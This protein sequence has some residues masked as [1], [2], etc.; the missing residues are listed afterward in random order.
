MQSVGG[1][2]HSK[3]KCCMGTAAFLEPAVFLLNQTSLIWLAVDR[4]AVREGTFPLPVFH[5]HLKKKCQGLTLD[6]YFFSTVFFLYFFLSTVWNQHLEAFNMVGHKLRRPKKLFRNSLHVHDNHFETVHFSVLWQLL[7]RIY[8][9][10]QFAIITLH[11][12]PVYAKFGSEI[13]T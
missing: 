2:G 5:R 13:F 10:I 4:L 3:A 6:K 11:R 1:R 12:K 8:W 9:C 7:Y